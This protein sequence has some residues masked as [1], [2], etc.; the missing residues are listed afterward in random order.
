MFT[1]RMLFFR[2]H[3]SPRYLV[4]AGRPQEALVSLRLISRFNGSELALGLND[5]R[6]HR[7]DSVDSGAKGG[8]GVVVFDAGVN[9]EGVDGEGDEEEAS[10]QSAL[11]P[12][13]TGYHAT[14]E[15]PTPLDS[16]SFATPVTEAPTSTSPGSETPQVKE[17]ELDHDHDSLPT[18]SHSRRS[19][20][21][22]THSTHSPPTC[23]TLPI[24]RS[25]H[26]PIHRLSLVLTPQWRR[27]T[28]LVWATWCAMALAYTM[29]NVF[30]PKLLETRAS[31]SAGSVGGGVRGGDAGGGDGGVVINPGGGEEKGLEETMWDV[32]IFTL[33]GCPGAI[34]SLSFSSFSPLLNPP[35]TIKLHFLSLRCCHRWGHT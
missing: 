28:L 30:L 34:V 33:G 22:S 23:L 18:P 21:Y 8:S 11:V 31:A 26:R 3:E 10:E 6:D 20:S 19:S 2:L 4:H 24:P 5:V 9:G 1:A 12:E 16:H 29:F 35:F 25:L 7:T 13:R 15:S 14:G 27:T 17:H 32:V